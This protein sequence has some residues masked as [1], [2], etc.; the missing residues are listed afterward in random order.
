MS[1]PNILFIMSDDHAAQAISAYGHGINQTP[2]IDRIGTEGARLNHCYVTNSICTPSR[3]AILTGTYNHVNGVTSLSTGF[4][5]RMPHVAKHL[6]YAGYQ[7]AIVGKWHLHEGPEHCP[8]GFDY[9]SVLPGQGEYFN[10]DMIEN[11]ERIVEEGYTTDIITD[12][13]IDWI[14]GRDKKRPFFMMCHHKAPHRSWEYHPKYDDLYTDEIPYPDSFD[15]D[16][17]NRAKAAIHARMRVES[18]LTYQDLDLV[19][20]YYPGKDQ[21]YALMHRRTPQMMVPF[22]KTEAEYKDFKLICRRT[23]EIFTFSNSEE[24]KKFKYQRYMQKY[25]RTVASIDESIGRLLDMLD[26]EG[27][28]DNTMV[29][30][31]SDQGFFL[32]EHGWYDKRFIYEESFRMPFLIR[33]PGVVSPG[34]VIDSMAC[35]VDFAPTWLDYAGAPIPSYVQGTSMRSILE[36]PEPPDW[37][38]TAYQRYWMN[39]D[40]N[41]NAYAHYGIRDHRYKLIY[42]YNEACDTPGSQQPDFEEK[43]WELFDTQE[44]PLELFNCFNQPDKHEIVQHM[45]GLLDDKMAE[46]GDVPEHDSQRVL[47]SLA[48]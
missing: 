46:I 17:S 20:P 38:Q 25:L 40:H 14:K 18:D 19:Q 12:K 26:E 34:S 43:D 10:P 23:G 16:Y 21:R 36:G 41:H 3:A 28:A 48:R 15:D 7:T 42:W 9:W 35:N 22:P 5:N 30:Y 4:N 13:C 1:S 37:Q 27:V 47:R 31:T 11:G 6:Q 33:F 8:T 44:D 45:L 32:G 2:N 39:Q 29:I 24:L